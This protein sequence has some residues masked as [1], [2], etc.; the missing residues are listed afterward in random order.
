MSEIKKNKNLL[1]FWIDGKAKPYVVDINT[2]KLYGLRGGEI[3]NVPAAMDALI[4]TDYTRF[5]VAAIYRYGVRTT[6]TSFLSL[7]DRIDALGYRVNQSEISTVHLRN[8]CQFLTEHFKEFAEYLTDH[9]N[10]YGCVNDFIRRYGI[11]V[12][13]TEHHLTAN[14]LLTQ[15]MI[16]WLVS[17]A[18]THRY[19]WAV[20]YPSECA[21]FL[22][23]GLWDFF[24]GDSC[25]LKEYLKNMAFLCDK[26]NVKMEKSDFFRQ[27]INLSR[28]YNR[29]K[30]EI[31]RAA[32]I[33]AQNA[34]LA[35]LTYENDEFVVVIPQSTADLEIEGRLQHNCVGGYGPAVKDG[36]RNVVFIRKKNDV[37]TPYIT[38]DI[39]S[40]GRINQYLLRY[41]NSVMDDLALAFKAE[42]QEHLSANW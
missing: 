38:C 10:E 37:N 28:E 33:A 17:Q 13:C 39:L 23:R 34:H 32:F 5:T 36:R 22:S 7:C 4:R 41:N 25:R 27:Y 20:K 30:N 26:L 1:E 35:A 21:Y 14:D 31:D 8:N 18:I 29:R 2:G 12:F 40:N 19:E 24:A 15:E 6:D 16:D 9:S 42:Y 11:T 3:Q